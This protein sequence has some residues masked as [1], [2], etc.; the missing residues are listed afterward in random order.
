MGYTTIKLSHATKK[1]LD[2][3]KHYRR[4]AYEDTIQ[5]ML[6]LLNLCRANPLQAQNTLRLR[7]RTRQQLKTE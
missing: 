5:T 7:E 6:D 4:E 2:N 3:L 1:R